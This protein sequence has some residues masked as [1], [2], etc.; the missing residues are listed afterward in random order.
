MKN[1]LALLSLVLLLAASC[2][3]HEEPQ[4]EPVPFSLKS[5]E[6]IE[7]SFDFNWNIFKAL[8]DEAEAGDNV[9]LSS[10][11][12]MQ[13][14][15]M[16]IS[17]AGGDNLD[18]MLSVFG[19]DSAEGLHEAYKN[20][21]EALASADPKVVTEIVNSAWYRDTYTI[22]ESFFETLGKYYDAEISGLDFSD[23]EKSKQIINSWVNNAT[24][25]KIP[26][27]VEDISPEHVLFLINAVYFNG[28]WSSKFD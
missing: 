18:E 11:S 2:D 14:F 26:S 9:V 13:A 20:I 17:G 28:E 10:L 16:A 3:K 15:G 12:I 19:F 1:I 23:E 27:I 4:P 5:A 21:R 8:N 22:K 7:Q 24:H 6:L 25:K